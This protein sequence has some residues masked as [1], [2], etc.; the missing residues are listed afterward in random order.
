[1]APNIPAKPMYSMVAQLL[2]LTVGLT[3][4]LFVSIITCNGG[5]F[6]TYQAWRSETDTILPSEIKERLDRGEQLAIVDVREDDEVAAGIIP[7][8][9]HIPLAQLP[10]RLSE[11]PQSKSLFSFAAAET[12]VAAQLASWRLKAIKVLKT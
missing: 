9:K 1:M 2:L 7:G 3:S 6:P 10:D 5:F 11:I 12:A 8:A 4:R